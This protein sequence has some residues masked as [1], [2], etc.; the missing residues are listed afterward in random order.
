MSANLGNSAVATGLEKVSFHS[1]PKEGQC[2]RMFKLR[3]RVSFPPAFGAQVPSRPPA[4]TL[5]WTFCSGH[6]TRIWA[7]SFNTKFSSEGRAP[8]GQ[9]RALHLAHP[10]RPPRVQ[11]VRPGLLSLLG[12]PG[13]NHC[14]SNRF[15]N[16]RLCCL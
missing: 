7:W 4:R 15:Q 1:N 5:F 2:Q 16:L 6:S 10:D 11:E 13:K 12:V 9:S 14:G 8:G 3:A